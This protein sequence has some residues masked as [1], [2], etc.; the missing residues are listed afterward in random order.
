MTIRFKTAQILSQP[1][2]HEF[3]GRIEWAKDRFELG[4]VGPDDD[5]RRIEAQ[6]L[7]P[8][9]LE[10]SWVLWAYQRDHAARRGRPLELENCARIGRDACAG[11]GQ[12]SPTISYRELLEE[13]SPYVGTGA[14][15]GENSPQPG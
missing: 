4:V 10:P 12:G 5:L 13:S 2:P 3:V 15:A 6:P 9:R 7:P 1:A 14:S 8:T 11:G